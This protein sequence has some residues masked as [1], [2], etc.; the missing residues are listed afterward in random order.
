MQ[1]LKTEKL[2]ISNKPNNNFTFEYALKREYNRNK[3]E[4]LESK[5]WREKEM[6]IGEGM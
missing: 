3:N 4:I 1:D 5:R 6:Q 2:N